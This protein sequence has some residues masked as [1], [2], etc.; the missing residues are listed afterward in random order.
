MRVVT[1]IDN[2]K[3]TGTVVTIGIFDGVHKGHVRI[4]DRLRELSS[5]YGC[6]SVVI[7]L[8]PHPRLVLQ[9]EIK[10]LNLLSTLDEKIELIRR[11]NIDN[12]VILPFTR[13][14]SETTFDKFVE[15]FLMKKTGV[16]HLVMGFNHHFG[17]G[18]G[19]SFARLQEL[20]RINGFLVERLEPVILGDSRVSSSGIRLMLEEG[21]LQSANAA[22][23]YSYF[24]IGTVVKG[25]Q[26]GRSIGFP[27]ANIQPD[28]PHKLIPLNGVYSAGV[29]I[30]DTH[31]PGMLNIGFR[32]TIASQK[33]EIVIEVHIFNFS[34]DLYDRKIR[35]HFYEWMRCE[36]KFPSLDALKEQ[37][38]TD[39]KE[40]LKFFSSFNFMVNLSTD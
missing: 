37:L 30:N 29:F 7:T 22:L 40:V 27:T 39:K 31:Y 18:R 11:H 17:K 6:E 8:W 3:V 33:H 23:G 1:N 20:S 14:L 38:E 16:R 19:G 10:K 36:K 4:L 9:P 26:L 34:G 24:I 28:E 32:P 12:L 25:N 5:A 13:E 21:R 2:F 15:G 35:V